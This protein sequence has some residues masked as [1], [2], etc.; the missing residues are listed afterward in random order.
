MVAVAQIP[1]KSKAAGPR[2]SPWPG[3]PDRLDNST[4]APGADGHK[5]QKLSE[6]AHKDQELL[7]PAQQELKR[8]GPLPEAPLSKRPREAE[9][10]PSPQESLEAQRRAAGPSAQEPVALLQPRRPRV[11][12]APRP[13]AKDLDM[14]AVRKLLEQEQQGTLPPEDVLDKLRQLC[15]GTSQTASSGAAADPRN[16]DPGSSPSA[17]VAPPR[18]ASNAAMPQAQP[19][20]V[21]RA[22]PL[23]VVPGRQRQVALVLD[24]DNT[25][26]DTVKCSSLPCSLKTDQE[27]IF[28]WHPTASRDSWCYIKLRPGVRPFLEV[29]AELFELYVFS[30]GSADYVRFIVSLLD[31]SGT[32]F[33]PSRVQTRD[34]MDSD[35]K[36]LRVV[37]TH[38]AER[39]MIFDDRLDVW[40]IEIAKGVVPVK[41]FLYKYFAPRAEELERQAREASAPPVDFDEHLPRA[42][43]FFTDVHKEVLGGATVKAARDAVLGRI[44]RDI[45]VMVLS[46]LRPDWYEK[47][48][49]SFGARVHQQLESSVHMV[50]VEKESMADPLI[51]VAL[52]SGIPCISTEW[53]TMSLASFGVIDPRP[54]ALGQKL[55]EGATPNDM[56]LHSCLWRPPDGSGRLAEPSEVKAWLEKERERRK[57]S[58]LFLQETNHQAA[59]RRL[60]NATLFSH[61]VD[62]I[63]LMCPGGPIVI[64]LD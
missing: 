18:A 19:Q 24:V 5:R 39:T 53:C 43:K 3:V 44:F 41:A 47:N 37:T 51:D 11:P 15:K 6:T 58:E 29:L 64:Q 25:L 49:T 23:A 20:A 54:F 10:A 34:D 38:P 63:A 50:L 57:Q 40:D 14:E 32:I 17:A 22:E 55:K 61:E 16:Q 46:R 36:H 35:K 56:W 42:Q 59:R 48:L 9:A 8:A 33:H 62:G 21:A 60:T 28:E 7:R 26:V 4:A 1:L 2:H 45:E 12:E 27:G 13:A 52:S 31:P 30:M